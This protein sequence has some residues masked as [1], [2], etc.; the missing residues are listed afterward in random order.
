MN[1]IVHFPDDSLETEPLIPPAFTG[2][3]LGWFTIQCKGMHWQIESQVFVMFGET[4]LIRTMKMD[5][6]FGVLYIFWRR[7]MKLR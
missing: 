6:Y 3:K 5:D 2:D 4:I 7:I 1:A